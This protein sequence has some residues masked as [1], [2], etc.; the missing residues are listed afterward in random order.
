MGVLDILTALD[1]VGAKLDIHP[2]DRTRTVINASLGTV[3]ADLLAGVRE[4]RAL[5][6]ATVVGRRSGHVFAAC[7]T[8]GEVTMVRASS[9]RAERSPT[10]PRP[11]GRPV[12]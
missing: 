7:T 10:D 3:D 6:L 5:V 2:T 9:P 1:L 12:A 11:N 4:Q 8:C